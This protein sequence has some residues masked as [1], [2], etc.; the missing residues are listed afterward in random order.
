MSTDTSPTTADIS[1][2]PDP[3]QVQEFAGR[4]FGTLSAGST[5][6]MISIGHRTALFDTMAGYSPVSS[7]QLAAL[8]GLHERYV[9]EWLGAMTTAQIVIYDP[10][11]HTYALPLEHAAVLT[12]AAGPNNFA[13]Q[14]QFIPLMAQVE[15]QVIE[16]FAAGGG[17]GYGEFERFH[18]IMAEQSTQINDAALLERTVPL[19][20]GLSDRL[21]SGIRV[22]DIGCG[23]GHA[24]NLL[25]RAY[26]DS[27]LIGYDFSETAITIARQEAQD[28]G[29]SNA[30]F[31]LRDAT[32]LSGTGV[33]GAI[34]AFDAIHDQ[35]HPATVLSQIAEH[36]DPDEGTFLMIDMRASS[37][38]ENNLDIPWAPFLYAVST[39]HCM[40]VSL[41]LD[42][43]GLG[44]VWGVETAQRMLAEA[45]FSD[46]RMSSVPED[47]INAYYTARR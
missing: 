47:F 5:A 16:C 19:V 3:E 2:G 6:L 33:F 32:D 40:T 9:R 28:W 13:S 12:R 23:R 42:G 1:E 43:D 11:D 14:M 41:A 30:R 29:L 37:N 8:A 15:D 27:E 39:M 10:D 46:V 31:E 26:P 20:P 34:I 25:A 35:A 22:A 17:V 7:A 36:L 38:L 44:T 18:E 4:L 21:R 45:G 24:I